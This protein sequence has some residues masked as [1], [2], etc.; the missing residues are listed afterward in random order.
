MDG[1]SGGRRGLSRSPTAR[2]HRSREGRVKRPMGGLCAEGQHRECGRDGEREC[3]AA[4]NRRDCHC[5]CH[6]PAGAVKDES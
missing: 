4:P 2:A 5:P 3:D 1:D 6:D